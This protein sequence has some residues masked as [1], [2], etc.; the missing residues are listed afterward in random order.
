MVAQPCARGAAPAFSL[1]KT[2]D[3]V[4]RNPLCSFLTQ[5]KPLRTTHAETL[6]AAAVD[7]RLLRRCRDPDAPRRPRLCGHAVRGSH[8]ATTAGH[9]NNARRTRT[10]R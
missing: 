4:A 7:R 5:E 2:R 8:Q 10:G 9:E 6:V 3:S 1:G